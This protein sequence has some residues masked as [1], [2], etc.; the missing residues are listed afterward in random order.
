MEPNCQ[1]PAEALQKAGEIPLLS[2]FKR[3]A[4]WPIFTR[5]FIDDKV[6]HGIHEQGPFHYFSRQ[7]VLQ[8]F[9]ANKD[10]FAQRKSTQPEVERYPMSIETLRG[11][12]STARRSTISSRRTRYQPSPRRMTSYQQFAVDQACNAVQSEFEGP[13]LHRPLA[14][15]QLWSDPL[16]HSLSQLYASL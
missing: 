4:P 3:G 10:E 15:R 2:P 11:N 13:L 12:R 1:R 16:L 6:K 8:M 14:K 5:K 7:D 9:E